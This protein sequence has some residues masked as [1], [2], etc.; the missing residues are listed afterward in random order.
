MEQL[1]ISA[2]KTNGDGAIIGFSEQIYWRWSNSRVRRANLLDI[3]QHLKP[4]SKF[5]C[6][7]ATFHLS[8]QNE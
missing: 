7:G 1:F 6:D 8:E 4:V 2:S 5:M 3:E